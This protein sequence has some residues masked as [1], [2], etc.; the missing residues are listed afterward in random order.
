MPHSMS[1]TYNF[2]DVMEGKHDKSKVTMVSLPG[3]EP[4]T[5]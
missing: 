3:I 4:A 1:V 5:F 2:I